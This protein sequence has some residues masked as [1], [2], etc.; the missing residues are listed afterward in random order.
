[1]TMNRR[2]L[3]LKRLCE[4]YDIDLLYINQKDDDE[5][6]AIPPKRDVYIPL[7][8]YV[9]YDPDNKK[10]FLSQRLINIKNHWLN[11][12]KDDLLNGRIN[13]ADYS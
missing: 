1:M 9:A 6:V 11:T 12:L 10:I 5:L 4:H 3:D 8:C 13:Y 7:K 2:L